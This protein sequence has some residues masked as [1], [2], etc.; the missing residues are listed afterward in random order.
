MS[1]SMRGHWP[2]SAV[3]AHPV[4]RRRLGRR[5]P[6]RGGG[7]MARPWDRP[8]RARAGPV[9][10]QMMGQQ[11]RRLVR[12]A[13]PA[14]TR[15][16]EM[17]DQAPRPRSIV[18]GRRS[19]RGQSMTIHMGVARPAFRS[20]RGAK[21]ETAIAER[22]NRRPGRSGAIRFQGGTKTAKNGPQT[23]RGQPIA[24]SRPGL[25]SDRARWG[26]NSALLRPAV[27]WLVCCQ[28]CWQDADGRSRVEP[29]DG[30]AVALA[31]DHRH[32]QRAGRSV[33]ARQFMLPARPRHHRRASAATSPGDQLPAGPLRRRVPFRAPRPADR[34]ELRSSGRLSGAIIDR[35]HRLRGQSGA[36]RSMRVI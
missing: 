25:R 21:V 5:G 14:H 35:M 28:P 1:A 17:G 11:A 16:P 12:V 26:P 2:D 27:A 32:G 22:R 24:R 13:R 4:D 8:V 31:R 18:A 20:G 3:H 29:G 33:R 36:R 23:A 9:V 19:C 6:T 34:D 15:L 30:G 7:R 10:D